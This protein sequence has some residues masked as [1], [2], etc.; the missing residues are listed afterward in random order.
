MGG[1]GLRELWVVPPPAFPNKQG[2]S[3]STCKSS[4]TYPSPPLPPSFPPTSKPISFLEGAIATSPAPYWYRCRVRFIS[5]YTPEA[6]LFLCAAAA[7]VL[8]GVPARPGSFW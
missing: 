8:P 4:S 6:V 7:Q 1:K 5:L 3:T 2:K